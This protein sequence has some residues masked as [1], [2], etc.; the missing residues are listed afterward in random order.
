MHTDIITP[1]IQRTND[2]C[3]FAPKPPLCQLPACGR[4]GKLPMLHAPRADE[5]VRNLFDLAASAFYDQHFEAVVRIEMDMKRGNNLMER[6]VLHVI[7]SVVKLP[8]MMIVNE[9]D[10]ADGFMIGFFP[11]F[12]Y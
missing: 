12:G 8:R 4:H 9:R 11:F 6:A 5:A 1:A 7:K 2:S 3:S 10:G